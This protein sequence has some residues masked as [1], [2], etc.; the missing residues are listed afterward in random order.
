MNLKGLVAIS[1][2]PGLFKLVSQNKS[3]FIL[4]S[5]DEQK[6]KLV[7]NLSTVKLASLEDITV[8]GEDDELKLVDIFKT[9]GTSEATIPDPKS[10]G[11]TL[12]AYFAI[13]AP[14]YDTD[15]VYTSDIKK[16][17]SWFNIIKTYPFFTEE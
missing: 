3:G 10:D 7:I 5:L 4:E 2:R 12:Q 11:K 16:I 6:L 8:F 1:G 17:I 13:V 15:R 9:M 14:G